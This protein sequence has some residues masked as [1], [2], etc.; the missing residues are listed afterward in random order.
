MTIRQKE[1]MK[2]LLRNCDIAYRHSGFELWFDVVDKLLENP[3]QNITNV[4][5]KIASERNATRISIER[6]LRT[7]LLKGSPQV[8]LGQTTKITNKEFAYALYYEIRGI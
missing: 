8:L 7:S 6:N 1:K 2:M 4:Y 5:E 3:D